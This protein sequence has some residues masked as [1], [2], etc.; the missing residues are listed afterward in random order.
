MFAFYRRQARLLAGRGV[1]LAGV[2]FLLAGCGPPTADQALDKA[3]KDNPGVTRMPV[4]RFEG[5][6]TVDGAPPASGTKLIVILTDPKQPQDQKKRP[7]PMARCDEQ[8]H[9]MFSTTGQ[10]DGV[11]EG[12]YILAFLQVKD[13][14]GHF[15]LPIARRVANAPGAANRSGPDQLKNL[16]NDPDKNAEVP[17]FK[18]DIKKPGITDAHFNLVV[19][20]KE[21]VAT[22]GPHAITELSNN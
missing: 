13:S 3:Y 21:P 5:T 18:V 6:V 22:P 1:A 14:L 7:R 8:G 20:G 11:D 4:A 15:A 19:E 17:E 16:Y 12:S 9:F 10:G 2:A